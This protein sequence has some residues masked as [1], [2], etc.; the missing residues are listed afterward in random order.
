MF[1]L[2]PL[3]VDQRMKFVS[4]QKHCSNSVSFRRNWLEAT[5]KS[6]VNLEHNLLL[7]DLST[8]GNARIQK[9]SLLLLHFIT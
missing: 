9:S 6:K 7:K 5:I 1:V 4:L 2:L 8:A 3:L